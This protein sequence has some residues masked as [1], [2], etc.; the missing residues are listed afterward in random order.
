MNTPD[1]RAAAIISML[2]AGTLMAGRK[3]RPKSWRHRGGT[4]E[5]TR[6]PGEAGRLIAA[7][8]AKRARRA[9]GCR[10]LAERD[11]ERWRQQ[12][13]RRPYRAPSPR[14]ARRGFFARAKSLITGTAA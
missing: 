13:A 11:A 2:A 14:R 3:F 10:P 5:H 8:D 12:I 9:E 7:A 1:H 4:P 6:A